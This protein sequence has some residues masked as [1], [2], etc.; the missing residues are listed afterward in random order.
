[1]SIETIL[2]ALDKVKRKSA[3][4]WVALCPC[5]A[6]KTPSLA[7]TE[8][9]DRSVMMHCFGCGANGMAVVESL[10]IDINELFEV[11]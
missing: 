3:G 6:E 8:N 7:V 11:R 5:H 1:M 9:S 2:N 4:K 10:G